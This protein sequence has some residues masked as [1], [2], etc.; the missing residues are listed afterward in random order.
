[1][2]S[3]LPD[4]FPL[5]AWSMVRLAVSEKKPGAIQA[6]DRLCRLY[7]KPILAYILRDGYSAEDAADLKQGFF[8]HL[9]LHNSLAD[10]ESLRIKLR[11]FL[12]TKL[13]S[14]LIDQYRRGNALKRGGGKVVALADLSREQQYL[15]EPVDPITPDIAYQRQWLATVFSTAM[16]DLRQDYAAR[17]QNELF[18]VL[19]PFIDPH[20]QPEISALALRLGRP[21]GTIKSDLSRLR[22]RWRDLIRAQIAATLE[23]DSDASITAELKELMGYR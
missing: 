17:G 1:M 22:A 2:A 4:A 9:L 14:F 19:A 12:L 23:D 10:A 15:I 5:T 3:S 7:D 16:Q 6:L 18:D 20:S 21:E 8:T 11:A 13:Q